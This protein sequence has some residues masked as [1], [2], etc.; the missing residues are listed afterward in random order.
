M[1]HIL[2]RRRRR[3]LQNVHFSLLRNGM[4]KKIGEDKP[5]TDAA[6][7]IEYLFWIFGRTMVIASR[8]CA[9]FIGGIC[10]C[11]CCDNLG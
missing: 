8:V 7:A 4:N 2:Y 6:A 3:S 11:V 1:W 9:H 5:Q 10:V